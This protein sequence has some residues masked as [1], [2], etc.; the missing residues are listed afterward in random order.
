MTAE[1][2]EIALN[3]EVYDGMEIHNSEGYNTTFYTT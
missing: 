2:L 3:A 1:V